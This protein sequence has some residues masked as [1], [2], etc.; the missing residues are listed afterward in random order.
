MVFPF[1]PIP[2]HRVSVASCFFWPC[3]GHSETNIQKPRV[4]SD[5]S[6]QTFLVNCSL[7]TRVSITKKVLQR[8]ARL[9][10]VSPQRPPG[11][12]AVAAGPCA[13]LRA[14][15][16]IE[17]SRTKPLADPCWEIR[18]PPRFA[19]AG[20]GPPGPFPYV[21]RPERGRHLRRPPRA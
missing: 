6:N 8:R 12:I 11:T 4:P 18:S 10:P 5:Q 15:R 9:R 13:P 21:P 16:G 3:I 17:E 1:F 14:Q 2:Y 19:A 20:E 7:C